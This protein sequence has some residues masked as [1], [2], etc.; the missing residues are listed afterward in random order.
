M[1]VVSTC[2]VFL[3]WL[4]CHHICLTGLL[5]FIC[6]ELN[7]W[8][9]WGFER[10]VVCTFLL[11][12]FEEEYFLNFKLLLIGVCIRI[13][14]F[15]GL[16]FMHGSVI[17]IHYIDNLFWSNDTNNGFQRRLYCLVS[18]LNKK[19]IKWILFVIL[20]IKTFKKITAGI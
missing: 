19:K 15:L 16:Y 5:S 8:L 20:C 3:W 9:N 1:G 18:W 7:Y 10:L 2:S 13:N 12:C 4:F 17:G 6:F 14:F 11:V